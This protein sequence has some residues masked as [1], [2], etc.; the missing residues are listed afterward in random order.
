MNRFIMTLAAGIALLQ[1][2][3]AFAQDGATTDW[4][5]K[6]V[7]RFLRHTNKPRQPVVV[8][9]E[10]VARWDIATTKPA[11]RVT[12]AEQVRRYRSVQVSPEQS[13]LAQTMG[14]KP[15]LWTLRPHA[16]QTP[17]VGAAST[18]P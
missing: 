17:E 7:V 15:V 18:R 11:V 2:I 16:E 14:T 13:A 1:G 3:P 6:P 12:R 4:G 10:A 8:S 5:T 9:P